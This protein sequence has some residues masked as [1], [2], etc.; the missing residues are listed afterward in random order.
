MKKSATNQRIGED[1]PPVAEK[2]IRVA[3]ELF[4]QQGFQATGINEVIEKSAVAKASFYHHFPSKYD[5]YLAC[6]ERQKSGRIWFVEGA[7]A[8]AKTPLDKFLAPID[9][10]EKWMKDCDFRGCGFSHA[11][12]EFTG[13]KDPLHNPGIS[14]Y[15]YL[16]DCF[17]TLATNL[18]ATGEKQ[19][20]KLNCD[21]ISEQ[22]LAIFVGAIQIAALQ[23]NKHALTMAAIQVRE[24]LD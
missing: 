23:K 5:L 16:Q 14:F 17:L 12:A 21:Q 11:L 18:V 7:I 1:N 6:L 20:K 9:S 24:L 4:Y 3:N 10:L 8:V 22:Y 2:I 19:Y 13:K 15:H